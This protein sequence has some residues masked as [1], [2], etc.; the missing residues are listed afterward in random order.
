MIVRPPAT[1]KLSPVPILLTSGRPVAI[2]RRVVAVI[3]TSLQHHFRMWSQAHVFEKCKERISPLRAY[4]YASFA[5]TLVVSI[6][7]VFAATDHRAPS[8]VFHG[9]TQAVSDVPLARH[10]AIQ[11]ST[12]A[13]MTALQCSLIKDP[14][15]PAGA[16]APP[17]SQ[18]FSRSCFFNYGQSSK[19]LANHDSNCIR[20]NRRVNLL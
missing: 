12:G 7:G 15:S 10:L 20:G 14:L 17:S 3:V 2:I 11:T 4:L 18:V 13:S 8:V 5:V 1:A 16:F 19:D 6:F 9:S